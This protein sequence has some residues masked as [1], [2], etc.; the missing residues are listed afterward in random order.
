MLYSGSTP[1]TAYMTDIDALPSHRH[2]EAELLYC[3][4]GEIRAGI[5]KETVS[6]S[7]GDT[8]LVGS[9]VPHF[10]ESDK[11]AGAVIVDFGYEL[12]QEDFLSLASS[13]V[14]Y[15]IYPS[16]HTVSEKIKGVKEIL[17]KPV[18]FSRFEL[19]GQIFCLC[20][21]LLRDL[22]AKDSRAD[23]F[24]FDRIA[25]AVRLV[26]TAYTENLT[27]EDACRVTGLAP[28]NFCTLFKNA[29]GTGFHSYLNNKRVQ[30]AALLLKQTDLPVD[31]V[32]VLSGFSDIKTFYRVFRRETG[33]S[34]LNFRKK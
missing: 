21:E 20:A 16:S 26:G 1:F 8:L 22:G 2:Y 11:R 10:Y 3:T 24:S 34:P 27:I 6:L 4:E 18:A 5:G 30:T 15:K 9:L 33:M 12:L 13:D 19:T 31:E 17:E 28:G 7:E 29:V 25:P 14:L 32:A 23:C